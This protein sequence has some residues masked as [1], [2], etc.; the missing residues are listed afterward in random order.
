M[1]GFKHLDYV[2]L[3]QDNKLSSILEQIEPEH[4]L[5]VIEI[6]SNQR[7]LLT[8]TQTWSW[9]NDEASGGMDQ[10]RVESQAAAELRSG[11]VP[12]KI[13]PLTPGNLSEPPAAP[14]LPG[15]RW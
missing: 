11:D 12:D 3:S 13:S 7:L 6:W 10:R 14:A 8:N 4:P 2:N 15:D 5:A 9:E 1:K